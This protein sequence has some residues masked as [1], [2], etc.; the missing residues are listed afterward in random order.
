MQYLYLDKYK[1][2]LVVFIKNFKKIFAQYTMSL[3]IVQ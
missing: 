1:I 3:A 2:L